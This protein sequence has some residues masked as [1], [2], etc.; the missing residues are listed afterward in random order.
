MVKAEL[1][2]KRR[3]RNNKSR[4]PEIVLHPRLNK[5]LKLRCP[6]PL[7]FGEGG[8]EINFYDLKMNSNKFIKL[9][10]FYT[11]SLKC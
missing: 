4:L 1:A 9:K 2:Q 8:Q 5:Y 10:S 3:H 11:V 7:G 6:G